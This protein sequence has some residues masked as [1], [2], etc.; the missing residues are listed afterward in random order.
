MTAFQQAGEIAPERLAQS[1]SSWFE[2]GMIIGVRVRE[3]D[4]SS[5]TPSSA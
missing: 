1:L 2:D 5:N 3:D 4:Q